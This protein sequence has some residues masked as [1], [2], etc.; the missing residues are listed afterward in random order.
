M[1]VTSRG[2]VEVCNK[3]VCQSALPINSRTYTHMNQKKL[4]HVLSVIYNW[5]CKPGLTNQCC[6]SS[7]YTNTYSQKFLNVY[8][9]V[10]NSETKDFVD[11]V[12]KEEEKKLICADPVDAYS[13]IRN[14]Y[15]NQNPQS[16]DKHSQVYSFCH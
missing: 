4:F 16:P 13:C 3:P 11:S 12:K 14:R 8:K 7:V 5:G 15:V 9:T 2:Q 10:A 6:Y 1:P